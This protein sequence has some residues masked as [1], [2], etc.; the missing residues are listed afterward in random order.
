MRPYLINEHC[1]PPCTTH[2]LMK[3]PI[4]NGNGC[5][6]GSRQAVL[7][8]MLACGAKPRPSQS[9][10]LKILG[11]TCMGSLS[12]GRSMSRLGLPLSLAICTGCRVRVKFNL[13]TDKQ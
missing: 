8:S 13:C 3:V 7:C 12:K 2:L 11:S 1:H 10:C 4:G 9:R 6:Q 5:R